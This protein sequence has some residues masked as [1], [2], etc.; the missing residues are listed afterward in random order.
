MES[1]NAI[2]QEFLRNDD[3]KSE[4]FSFLSLKVASLETESQI[5]VTH[6]KDV[7]C[8]QPRD[9]TDLAP[10]THEE[11]DT[12]MFLHVSDAVNHGYCKVMIRTVDSDVLVLAIA[13]VQQLD[14]DELWVAFATGKSFRYLPA[15]E[16]A[17]VLGPEKCI[18]L[19]FLHA[20]SGCDTV[21]SFAGRG[22]KT[23][24]E[25]WKT[26]IE[27]TPAFCSLASTPSSVDDQLEV[28]ERFV[29]LLYDRTSTAEKVNEARKQLF[30]QKS[31]S[32]DGLP[33]T[34]AALK[35]HTK[36]AAYQAGHVWAQMF[37][38]VPK[39]PSPGEWG[40]LQTSNGGWEV[41]WTALP[42]RLS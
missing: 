22:K 11:A 4:L 39:L 3:N 14:I 40:W 30:S 2:R 33:P 17:S 8:T 26:F 15:H 36:R 18:A 16:M 13:A 6:H 34:R 7:L 37:I 35:E 20:F 23:V 5:I 41:K 25:I 1:S 27:V 12:R 24:W 21:S 19:P 42:E 32:M 9:T 29:V 31:R 10:C 28:L 38:A